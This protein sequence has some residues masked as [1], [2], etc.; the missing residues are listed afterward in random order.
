V[1]CQG[2]RGACIV[3]GPV[4]QTSGEYIIVQSVVFELQNDVFPAL[5]LRFG[6]QVPPGFVRFKGPDR[7]RSGHEEEDRIIVERLTDQFIEEM[8]RPATISLS[9]ARPFHLFDH[10][11]PRS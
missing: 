4:G 9:T 3:N 10:K 5:G 11:G 7:E 2:G 1:A 6:T 8:L